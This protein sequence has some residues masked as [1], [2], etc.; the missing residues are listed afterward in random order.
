MSKDVNLLNTGSY[1]TTSAYGSAGYVAGFGSHDP[2]ERMQ[3]DPRQRLKQ[4]TEKLTS[5]TED[6]DVGEMDWTVTYIDMV[7]LLMIFFVVLSFLAMVADKPKSTSIHEEP[8]PEQPRVEVERNA[9]ASPFDGRG[10]SLIEGGN[11]Q[12]H[13]VLSARND[14]G[15]SNFGRDEVTPDDAEIPNH[16]DKEEANKN[17]DEKTSNGVGDAEKPTVQTAP[18]MIS[19]HAMANENDAESS[20]LA[21]RLQQMVQQNN[22]DG[23]VEVLASG[24]TVTVRISE[25]ILFPSGRSSLEQSG[26][27]LVKRLGPLLKEGGGQ[28]SIEGH[29]D[30]VPINTALY[31]SNWELSAARASMV[32]RSLIEQGFPPE[33]LRA[34]AY[35]DT[36]P[37]M[38]NATP[39]HRASN[40]RV[41][42][43]ISSQKNP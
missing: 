12:D 1:G 6:D 21:E 37:V 39:E 20:A 19:P 13:T 18:L 5:S 43:V 42:M 33:R 2:H 14:Q 11:P 7:T 41:E 38:D 25:K 17:T 9:G 35:A 4:Q 15:D 26:E 24:Q 22:L 29:T 23:Q 3:E 32:V 16:H 28:I 27:E 34:I 10:F 31:P 8:Y 30:N 36:K 40:R